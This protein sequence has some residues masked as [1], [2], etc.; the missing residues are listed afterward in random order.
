MESRVEDCNVGN[1]AQK[2]SS[3]TQHVERRGIV[4]RS[5]YGAALQLVQH[6]L[7][8][9]SWTVQIRSAVDNAVTDHDDPFAPVRVARGKVGQCTL[10]RYIVIRAAIGLADPFDIANGDGFA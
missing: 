1:V 10:H 7:V 8:D 4:E 9:Q 2:S 6:R 5:E 3:R